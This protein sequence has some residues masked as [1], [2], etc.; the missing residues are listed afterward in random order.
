MVGLVRRPVDVCP[1]PKRS[2]W[3]HPA[4]LVKFLLMLCD[5]WMEDLSPQDILSRAMATF[6]V[7]FGSAV[8][9]DE[10]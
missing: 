1:I 8:D 2:E 9:W 5:V 10:T 3:N 7:V 6:L 4:V